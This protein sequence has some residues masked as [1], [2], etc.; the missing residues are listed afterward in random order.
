[1]SLLGPTY[2]IL[3]MIDISVMRLNEVSLN[4]DSK[5][6][7]IEDIRKN[8]KAYASKLS[9]LEV[10]K[11]MNYL[12]IIFNNLETIKKSFIKLG[13]E[14]PKSEAKIEENQTDELQLFTEVMFNTCRYN[15][16]SDVKIIDFYME[17][18][19]IVQEEIEA[20][21]PPILKCTDGVV[22]R[23]FKKD[24]FD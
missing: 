9:S 12:A 13:F 18:I 4:E 6:I 15:F 11:V 7:A 20:F 3:K 22:L 24:I 16:V 1:M 23:K 19:I 8:I 5:L 2:N 21:F 14:Y 10:E 17:L